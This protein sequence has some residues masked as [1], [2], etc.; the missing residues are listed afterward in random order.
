MQSHKSLTRVLSGL[1]RGDEAHAQPCPTS[2]PRNAIQQ[3]LP[4]GLSRSTTKIRLSTMQLEDAAPGVAAS[5]R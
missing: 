1:P 4:G 5:L 3:C 2:S